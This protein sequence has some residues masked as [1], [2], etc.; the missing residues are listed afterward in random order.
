M[1]CFLAL[2]MKKKF[3]Y[4]DSLDVVGIH[5]VGGVVG[6]LMIGF[7]ADNS[8]SNLVAAGYWDEEGN[9]V[10]AS[11]EGLFFSGNVELLLNQFYAVSSTIAYSALGTFVIAWVLK[12]TIGLRAS[13]EAQIAGL[14]HSEH[15]SSSYLL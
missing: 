13:D 7:L 12:K 4:D 2:G 1:L 8:V 14:D 11:L 10:E 6:A 9:W 5:G 15:S 3:N